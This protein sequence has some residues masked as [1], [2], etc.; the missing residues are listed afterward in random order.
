MNNEFIRS[1]CG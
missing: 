1:S